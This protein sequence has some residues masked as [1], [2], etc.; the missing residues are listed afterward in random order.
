M[1]FDDMGKRRDRQRLA[2]GFFIALAAVA[3]P[4]MLVAVA[5]TAL[6]DH[7][8]C[9]ESLLLLLIACEVAV[10]VWGGGAS[11]RGDCRVRLT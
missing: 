1:R 4:L 5:M 10:L 2:L 8:V 9:V 6:F 7:H 3:I 11:T